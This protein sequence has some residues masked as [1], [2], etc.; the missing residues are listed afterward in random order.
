MTLQQRRRASAKLR[1]LG[2]NA[3]DTAYFAG[4]ADALDEYT[5]EA[6]AWVP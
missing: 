6:D 1:A 5:E 2:G 3:P 4:L